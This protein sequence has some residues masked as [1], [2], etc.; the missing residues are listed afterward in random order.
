MAIHLSTA[1]SSS[2]DK[3]EES[4]FEKWLSKLKEAPTNRQCCYP[5]LDYFAEDGISVCDRCTKQFCKKCPAC[6]IC[7]RMQV[8]TIWLQVALLLFE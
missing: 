2:S 6:S 5:C 3:G 4:A 8:S 7:E 1:D